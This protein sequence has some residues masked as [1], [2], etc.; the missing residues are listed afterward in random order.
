MIEHLETVLEKLRTA[1]NYKDDSEEVFLSYVDT[2]LFAL[3]EWQKASAEEVQEPQVKNFPGFKELVSEL[4]VKHQELMDITT[5]S[6][7]EVQDELVGI[8]SRAKAIRK[9]IDVLP[10]RVSVTRGKKG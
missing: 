6:R 1:F 2:Y 5:K 4:R 7:D 8:K 3:E 10:E 9:Y